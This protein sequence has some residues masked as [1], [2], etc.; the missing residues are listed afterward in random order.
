VPRT[1]PF[2]AVVKSHDALV[3]RAVLRLRDVGCIVKPFE[4]RLRDPETARRLA[5]YE[6]CPLANA[7]RYAPDL[8]VIPPH[9][10][11]DEYPWC[12]PAVPFLLELKHEA[13]GYPNV[14]LEVGSLLAARLWAF[15]REQPVWYTFVQLPQ[16]NG[17]AIDLGALERSLP[18]EFLV[19]D[20]P[21]NEGRKQWMEAALGIPGRAVPWDGGSGTPLLL[22]PKERLHL[23]FAQM[24]RT[25]DRWQSGTARPA[26]MRQSLSP[27]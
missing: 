20:R 19:P 11:P 18:R 23:D 8:L 24:L 3:D 12:W 27:W 2:A 5:E 22:I 14:S 17:W 4:K 13:N 16:G 6:E 26:E 25:Y 9:E 10:P 7:L 15:E 1:E 21:D